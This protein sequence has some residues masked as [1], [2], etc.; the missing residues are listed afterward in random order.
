MRV[1]AP[2]NLRKAMYHGERALGCPALAC[3]TRSALSCYGW[4]VWGAVLRWPVALWKQGAQGHSEGA[5]K[6]VTGCA[7]G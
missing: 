7:N 5:S 3:C 1:P 6:S 2:Y 4:G